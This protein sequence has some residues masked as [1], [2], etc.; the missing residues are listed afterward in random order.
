ME[1]PEN[2]SKWLTMVAIREEV[3]LVSV[4]SSVDVPELLSSVFVLELS[5]FVLESSVSES[6]SLVGV[7][8]VLEVSDTG[9]AAS[10]SFAQ[11][12]ITKKIKEQME[13]IN[14]GFL[15]FEKSEKTKNEIINIENNIKITQALN[16]LTL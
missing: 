3:S 16:L 15:C 10:S 6:L 12:T 13:V 1:T 11:A 4:L 9:G 7:V 5:V 2:I 8:S 14:D